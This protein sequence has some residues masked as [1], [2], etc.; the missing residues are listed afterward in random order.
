MKI[1]LIDDWRGCWRLLSTHV[2]TFW[3]AVFAFLVASPD[4]LL[5]AWAFLPPELREALP[6]WARSA[7]AFVLFMLSFLAARLTKQPVRGQGG[8]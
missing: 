2:A 4:A 5:H 1:Q 7:I 8:Q 3:A 6:P